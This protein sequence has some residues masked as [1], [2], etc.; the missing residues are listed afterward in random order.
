MF[1]F[2]SSLWALLMHKTQQA[3]LDL[4]TFAKHAWT[5]AEPFVQQF[6]SEAEQAILS[7]L[8]ILAVTAIQQVASQGLPTT[9]AKQQAFSKIMQDAAKT[10][11][12]TLTNELEDDI[13]QMALRIYNAY[14]ASTPAA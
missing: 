5:V 14:T 2:F 13:R 7:S 8:Q 6:F 1:K 11:G 9:E 10:Q 3:I 4:G 12:L